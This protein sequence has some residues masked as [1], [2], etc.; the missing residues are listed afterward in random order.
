MG[1]L[2]LGIENNPE[3]IES[4]PILSVEA[5]PELVQNVKKMIAKANSFWNAKDGYNL[6]KAREENDKF[7]LGKQ[8]DEMLL[9]AH[10][11]PYIDNQIYVGAQSVMA[12]ISARNPVCEII[13]EDDALSSVITAQRLEKVIEAHSEKHNL[14]QIIKSAGKSNY[15]KRVGIIKLVWDEDIDDVK[16]KFI[17]AEN[18]ILDHNAQ[19]G[20]NPE[21]IA[22]YIKTTFSKLCAKF[23][24]KKKEIMEEL[25][26][27]RETANRQDHEITYVECWFTDNQSGEPEEQ[28]CWFYGDLLLDVKK[29]P[30]Y[31]Y[32]EEGINVRNFL[33]K[34]RKP[35]I[36]L[37]YIND[38]TKLIDQTTPIEQAIPLQ[39]VLNKRGRQIVDNADTANSV[40][41]YDASAITDEEAAQVIRTPNQYVRLNNEGERPLNALFTEIQ[42]HMLP[43]YVLQDKQDLRNA[44]NNIL[45]TP[46][47][48]RGDDSSTDVSTL[49]EAQMMKNQ[50]SGRQDEFVEAIDTALSEYFA[51]LIQFM[52]VY[53]TEPRKYA[54]R[55]TDGKF[56]MVEVRRETMPEIASVSVQAGSS[57]RFDKNRQEQIAMTLAK[58]GLTDPYTLFKNLSLP[59]A[60][61]RYNNL[62][63]FKENPKSLSDKIASDA[64]N[65]DAYIDFAVIMKGLECEARRDATPEHILAHNKQM[66]SPEFLYA[67]DEYRRALVEHVDQ[68]TE[69]I[70]TIMSIVEK[71]SQALAPPQPPQQA[72]QPPVGMEG[73]NPNQPPQ[74]GGQPSLPPEAGGQVPPEVMAQG[75]QPPMPPQGGVM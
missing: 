45:G 32:K 17:S 65:E 6:A 69:Y 15:L 59:D 44:I 52:K 35:Y 25:Q 33:D 1:K 67:D 49:G 2:N 66:L 61:D 3:Q 54:V 19:L 14:K 26:W 57:V 18:V 60:E 42:P 29:N 22:E 40:L 43:N 20:E 28:V 53:Y 37:N 24:E 16:P 11:T 38:G 7:F 21:F 64:G 30:H 41:V 13:P 63:A 31:L 27:K 71:T 56:L 39:K 8:V 74:Q 46:S 50:A 36:F 72:S 70:K 4:T 68:E 48:F 75:G 23:P 9:H 47:Q 10:Q 5:K 12:Y 58:A 55:D 62:I 51:L 34:P 73:G